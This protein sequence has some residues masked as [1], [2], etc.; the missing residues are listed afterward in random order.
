[1]P[2][3]K[4]SLKSELNVLIRLTDPKTKAELNYVITQLASNYIIH[5][6]ITEN[7]NS[8]SD[9]HTAMQGAADEFKRL[10]LDKYEDKKI[11]QNGNA[12]EKLLDYFEQ[13]D[14]EIGRRVK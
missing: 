5:N 13:V 11:I 7:Y 10:I 14:Q 1:M 12:F 4:E 3:I 8:L 6:D 2:H 9:V